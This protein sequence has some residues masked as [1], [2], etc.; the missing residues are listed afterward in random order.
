MS[1]GSQQLWASVDELVAQAPGVAALRHHR[2]ELLAARQQRARGLR[3]DPRLREAERVAAVRGV[4]VRHLL[5]LIRSAVD[6]PLVLMKG[7]EVAASYLYPEC[8]PFGDLDI[9]TSHVDAAF[10]ALLRAGFT[11]TGGC[12]SRHHAAPLV[13]P[14]VPLKIELHSSANYLARLPAPRTDEL[15]R[16]TRP[17]RTGVTGIEGFVPAV[18]AV[19][20]AVHAWVHEPLHHVGRLVDVAAVLAE[21]ERREADEIALRWGCERLWRTTCAAIDALLAQRAPSMPL[22][23]WA[24]HLRS[25][26]EPRVFERSLA[27]I[28]APIWGL[29]RRGVPAGVGAEL[30]RAVRRYEWETR[31]E[32]MLRCRLALR[33]PFKPVSEFRA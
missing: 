13:W 14:G 32:H 22:R 16:Q 25:S 5:G 29:P 1:T 19:L 12:D 31:D 6:H 8:R 23:T 28:V 33:R 24:R 30:L 17:S 7:P 15:L 3:V 4:S 2:L 11:E 26:R 9:L 27:R 20:L 10:D 18:H 21:T